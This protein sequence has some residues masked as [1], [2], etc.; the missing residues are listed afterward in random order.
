MTKLERDDII[1]T[2]VA[3]GVVIAFLVA[4]IFSR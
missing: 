4:I 2:V 1:Y 3:S